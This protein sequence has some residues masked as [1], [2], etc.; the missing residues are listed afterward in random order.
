[1]KKESQD[2]NIVVYL[3]NVVIHSLSGIYY[4]IKEERSL[5]LWVIS[6]F[7][8]GIISFLLKI[9]LLHLII[10]FSLQLFVFIVELLNT[11]IENTVDLITK[12]K[13]IL[14]KKAKDC[15]SAA[16]FLAEIIALIIEIYIFSMYL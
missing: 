3:Y 7:I 5:H 2:S 9:S 11:G 12:E 1:M 13:N 16:S 10:I 14:A 6:S 4:T 8:I 15:G